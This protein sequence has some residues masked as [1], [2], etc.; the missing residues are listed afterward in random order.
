MHFAEFASASA[1]EFEKGC[2]N[3]IPI[4]DRSFRKAKESG[5]LRLIRTSCKAF[6][7][8]ADE[9]NGRYGDF[10]AF[11]QPY[12]VE[13]KLQSLPLEPFH[14]SR[15]NVLFANAGSVFF[16][17]GKM[18]DFLKGHQTNVLLKSVLF[19]LQVSEFVAGCKSLGLVSKLVT[20]P[21]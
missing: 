3:E 20:Q 12:R 11:I 4:Y 9:K 6:A 19:D 2:F 18:L 5:T 16:L 10:G 17:H 7:R 13:N 8:G 14:G 1:L 15:F 21:L